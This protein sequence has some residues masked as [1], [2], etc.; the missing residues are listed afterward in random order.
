MP[1]YLV[2]DAQRQ[3]AKSLRQSMT[4]AER[5]LW[6]YLKAHHLDG[7]GFRRQVPMGGYIADFV[8]HAARL[9]VELDGE[10]HDFEARQRYDLKRDAWFEARGYFVLHVPNEEVLGN[11]EGTWELIRATA[12]E[13]LH[14]RAPP[15]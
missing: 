5:L 14:L 8:C 4:R 6:R 3:R 7:L 10:T 2:S 15:P 1:R 12:H 11:L 13:R 9:V